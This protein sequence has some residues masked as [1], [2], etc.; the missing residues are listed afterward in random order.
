[1]RTAYFWPVY[2]GSDEV[3]FSFFPTRAA[4]QVC[5]VLG[6]AHSADAVLSTDG[7]AAYQSY[8]EEGRPHARAV[9]DSFET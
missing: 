7:Y 8:R 6:A 2:G 9:L 1:M 5:A 3:S 4:E